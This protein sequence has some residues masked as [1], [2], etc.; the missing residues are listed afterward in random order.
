MKL[1][2]TEEEVRDTFT[3]L[4]LR[5]NALYKLHEQE[6]KHCHGEVNNIAKEYRLLA[7]RVKKISKKIQIKWRAGE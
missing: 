3:A 5:A 1:E 4:D 2:L 7:E 6:V